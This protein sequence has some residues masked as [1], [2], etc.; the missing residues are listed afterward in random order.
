VVRQTR[1]VDLDV[2]RLAVVAGDDD[3]QIAAE[4][5]SGILDVLRG[6]IRREQF[7]DVTSR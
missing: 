7:V 5:M 4:D 6:T 1:V 3:V 2:S